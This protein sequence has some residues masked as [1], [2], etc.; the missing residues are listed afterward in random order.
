MNTEIVHFDSVSKVYSGGLFRQRG[1]E[2]V[3]NVTLS[4]H[5]GETF[6]LIGPNGAG[7]TTLIRM[8]LDFI[9]PTSGTIQMFGQV[10]TAP[11]LRNGI[12]YFPE[13]VK[14]PPHLTVN[15]F[16]LYWGKFSGIHENSLTSRVDG[17]LR[18]VKLEEKKNSLIK[19]LSKGMAV[20]VG[21]AQA[22]LND[23]SLLILDEPTDGLDPLGRI[24]F[25][26]MLKQ[27]K[28]RGKTIFINSHL[29]SEVEQI[30]TRVGVMDKGELIKVDSLDNLL[31]S[32]YKITIHFQCDSSD[33]VAQLRARFEIKQH[34]NNW[35]LL[36]VNPDDLDAAM[37]QLTT[38]GSTILSVDKNQNSLENKFLSLLKSPL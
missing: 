22:L 18:F 8:L 25:R 34:G 10:N 6:C 21:L 32:Q 15:K 1:V 26:D 19:D 37:K 31:A 9:K 23:P 36:L 35:D 2:A 4:L 11:S 3:R 28:A 33:A 27:L 29:L 16:L 14:Y 7:K 12:G 13:R 17:L 20:R 24:E 30:S 5:E 38:V